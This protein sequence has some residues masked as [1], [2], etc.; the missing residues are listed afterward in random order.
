[1]LSEPLKF[2]VLKFFKFQWPEV[3]SA[4]NHQNKTKQNKTKQNKTK[5]N[6]TKHNKTKQN[7][8]KPN[9]TKPNKTKQ[10]KTKPNQTKPNKTKQNQ[11]KPN[12]TKQNKT[13]QNKTKQNKTLL[14]NIQRDFNIYIKLRTPEKIKA[15][16]NNTSERKTALS[17]SSSLSTNEN[18]VTV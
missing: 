9:Q 13:K 12:Q 3:N 1:M 16:R 4:P 10:N 17:L 11:T 7:K 15:T 5:Q 8:T 14:G 6:T 2:V 18:V